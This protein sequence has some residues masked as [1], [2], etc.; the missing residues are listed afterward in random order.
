PDHAA[1]GPGYFVEMVHPEDRARV[2]QSLVDALAGTRELK[3]DARLVRP[4]GTVA[5]VQGEAAV[6]RDNA[7]RPTRMVGTLLDITER[8][9]VEDELRAS[10]QRYRRIV[11]TTREGVWQI[12]ADGLL[13]FVNERLA[14]MLGY[15][16]SELV[17]R[18]FL[19]YVADRAAAE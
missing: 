18:P 16:A 8:K 3:V 10:E 2:R 5:W 9:R 4:D 6:E 17:G 15:T 11:E 1:A 13:S 19:D 14:A 7:G 12:D